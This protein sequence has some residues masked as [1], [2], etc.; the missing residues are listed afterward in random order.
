M[1]IPFRSAV[2]A[3][4]LTLLTAAA[5]SAQSPWTAVG[6]TGAVDE[7]SLGLFATNLTNLSYAAASTSTTS[8]VARYN[9]TN[10]DETGGPFPGAP[11]WSTLEIGYVEPGALGSI[12]ARL[13]NVDLCTGQ[14]VSLC[15][16]TSDDGT[17]CK[18]CT[19]TTPFDF[20]NKLY[21]VEVTL[22]RSSATVNPAIRALRIQ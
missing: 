14:I 7:A 20:V 19:F 13:M 12:T 9:V 17:S 18:R 1:R 2:L 8:I 22:A 6:S 10:T 16:V 15:S 3:A 5:G 21:W 11:P 4:S